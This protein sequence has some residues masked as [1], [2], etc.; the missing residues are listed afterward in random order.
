MI[1]GVSVMLVLVLLGC[2]V[3][4]S[5]LMGNL[6]RYMRENLVVTMMIADEAPDRDV[7]RY[8]H[9]L[10]GE[11]YVS[12][13]TL[14]SREQALKEQTEAMG[15]DPSEFVG[16]NPFNATIELQLAADYA[17]TD[18]LEWIAE[19]L[20]ASDLVTDVVYQKDIV[21]V[22]NANVSRITLVLMVLAVLLAMISIVLINNTVRLSIYARRFAI[23]TMRLV[24]A[25]WSFIR[26]PFVK[27]AFW[28][29]VVSAMLADGLVLMGV[30]LLLDYDPTI[31]E[32]VHTGDLVLM[33]VVILVVGLA[34]TVLC[35]LLTVNRYLRMKEQDMY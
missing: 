17:N 31:C 8:A 11:S 23:H 2:I 10:E 27:R 32:F 33:S 6:S 20:K 5:C 12:N 3:F 9:F 19:R 25:S 26:R 7:Q 4:F 13:V 16:Y 14:V 29:G 24:G 30:Y 35:S 15:T 18:S 34:I 28:L 1:S 22:V 21:D